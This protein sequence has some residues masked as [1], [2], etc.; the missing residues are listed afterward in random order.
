MEPNRTGHDDFTLLL[1]PE[2]TRFRAVRGL[3]IGMVVVALV[4]VLPGLLIAA[5]ERCQGPKGEVCPS[6]PVGP[7]GKAV[8]DRF[9]FVH[10][11]LA[12][13][14]SITVRLT[15][16]TGLITYPPPNHN[17]I[18]PGVV[19]WAKAGVIIKESTQQGTPYA[20]IMLTGSHGVRMQ[21]NYIADTAG[22]P[23]G[24]SAESPRW[25]RLTR[26]GDMLT[27][28]ESTDGT[29]WTTVG[30]ADLARLPA[31]VVIGF[32]VTSPG[33]V[34]VSEGAIRFTN[35]TAVFDHVSLQ[36]T[37]G[38]VW[39]HDDIGAK[40]GLPDY[41]YGGVVEGAGG[42]FTVTGAG[43]IAPLGADGGWP[44][45]R[46]LIGT[47]FGLMVVIVVA[48]LFVTAEYRQNQIHTPQ[49]TNP[50]KERVLAAKA[51]AISTVTFVAGLAAAIVTVLLGRQILPANGN[52]ILPV[53]PLT[54]LRVV[55]GTAALLAV[56]SVFALALGALLRR[57]GAAV[58]TS[59][60]VVAIPYI[61]AFANILPLGTS[62]WLLRLTPA[63]GFAIQQSI[64]EY[65]QVIGLYTP[66]LGYYPLAPWAGFAVL[67]GYTALAFGV[68]VF[69]LRRRGA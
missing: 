26:S 48:V 21:S 32:F 66:Q 24:V 39:S 49:L 44:I 19:P 31:T 47:L 53:T 16:M 22:L 61:L 6:L 15:S 56:T 52:A 59:I 2:W 63:A 7:D 28:D 69:L 35:A 25:L 43:D 68:A 41:L 55:F 60:A 45:E 20:A 17:E 12:G 62:Q 42:T 65:P 54:E 46:T 4:I 58:T 57:R 11:P 51:I 5:V 40:S 8:A 27:G 36:G 34:T 67:C 9:Y 33:N 14:G 50:R 18:V 64:P 10:R 29:Q 38:G 3:V 23:G 30:T 37:P 1:R 13:D